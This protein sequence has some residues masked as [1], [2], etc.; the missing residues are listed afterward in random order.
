MLVSQV[1]ISSFGKGVGIG[2]K[3]LGLHVGWRLISAGA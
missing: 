1:R 3:T 2:V